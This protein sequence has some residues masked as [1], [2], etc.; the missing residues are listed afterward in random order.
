M[1]SMATIAPAGALTVSRGA[2]AGTGIVCTGVAARAIE[3]RVAESVAVTVVSRAPAYRQMDAAPPS[4]MIAA[5]PTTHG[6]FATRDARQ[7]A[8][9]TATIEGFVMCG[10]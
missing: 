6:V 10:G 3:S 2:E 5:A 8:G 9:A 1:P 4:N 7:R